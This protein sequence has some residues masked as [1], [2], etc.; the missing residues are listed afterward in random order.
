MTMANSRKEKND[1]LDIKIGG[2]IRTAREKKGVSLRQFAKEIDI[3]PSAL[4]K[5]EKGQRSIDRASLSRIANLLSIDPQK[6]STESIVSSNQDIERRLL[7]NAD[8]VQIKYTFDDV[9]GLQA[10]DELDITTIAR[11]WLIEDV[12]TYTLI[13]NSDVANKSVPNG[14]IAAI[15]PNLLPQHGEL[16][17]CE[18][19]GTTHIRRFYTTPATTILEADSYNSD[20]LPIVVTKSDTSD[21]EIKGVVIGTISNQTKHL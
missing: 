11:Q 4:S 17:L 1:E 10:A 8:N 15:A 13:I 7:T 20:Y 21:F 9:H 2:I 5:W 14:H 18:L 16:I 12:D 19:D 3:T 6:L